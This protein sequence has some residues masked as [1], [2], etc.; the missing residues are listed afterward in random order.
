[1]SPWRLAMEAG[2]DS[3]AEQRD[4]DVE[5][6]HR[7]FG[8]DHPKRREGRTDLELRL[9]ICADKGQRIS[10]SAESFS[11]ATDWLRHHR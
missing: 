10:L 9:P 2:K 1:M 5:R 7:D 3:A 11:L 6:G 4:V 8:W